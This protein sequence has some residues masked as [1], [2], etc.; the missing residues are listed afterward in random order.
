MVC[1]LCSL[2]LTECL[3]VPEHGSLSAWSLQSSLRGWLLTGVLAAGHSLFSAG[4]IHWISS[5]EEGL[6]GREAGESGS[7][8]GYSAGSL[9]RG[10]FVKVHAEHWGA[11]RTCGSPQ[12]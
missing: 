8:P 4:G 10:M 11:Q 2:T 12:H 3:T 5:C 6:R 7:S 9:R 1:R